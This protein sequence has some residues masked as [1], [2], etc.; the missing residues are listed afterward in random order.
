MNFRHLLPLFTA[1]FLT[2]AAAQDAPHHVE[3]FGGYSHTFYYTYEAHSGPWLETG[4]NGWQLEAAFPLLPHFAAETEFGIGYGP[5]FSSPGLP[6]LQQKIRTYMGGPRFDFKAHGIDFYGHAMFG[7]LTEGTSGGTYYTNYNT[8]FAMAF[9]GG[10]DIW[11]K[12]HFGIRPFSFDYVH[13]NN[14]GG[15]LAF[16]NTHPNYRLTMGALARF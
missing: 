5:S 16:H 8:S 1:L 3:L 15:Y 10:V 4:Y 14:V 9:G 12:R 11:L 2:A 6:S 7:G 13:N